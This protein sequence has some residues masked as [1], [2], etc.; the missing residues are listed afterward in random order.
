MHDQQQRFLL[1]KHAIESARLINDICFT[2]FLID[3]HVLSRQLT[4][5]SLTLK[6]SLFFFQVF[7]KTFKKL[8]ETL[9]YYLIPNLQGN[10]Q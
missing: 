6:K 9:A 5:L 4:R 1:T 3:F 10:Y 2:S 8:S 7:L